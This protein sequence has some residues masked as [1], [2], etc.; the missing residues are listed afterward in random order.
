MSLSEV[1]INGML[2]EYE[3]DHHTGMD[4]GQIAKQISDYTNGYPFLVSRICELLDTIVKEKMGIKE[5]WTQWGLDEAIK[6]IL[7]VLLTR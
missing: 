7:T 3:A 6:L 2:Q 4:C 1:G 5:A